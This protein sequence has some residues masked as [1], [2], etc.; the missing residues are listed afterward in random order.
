[1][2]NSNLKTAF[3]LILAI[4]LVAIF[5]FISQTNSFNWTELYRYQGKQPYD[6]KLVHD[7][8]EN[9]VGSANFSIQDKSFQSQQLPSNSA[10]V[11]IGV[12]AFYDPEE[13]DSLLAWVNQ[14]NTA[15]FAVK[16]LD[17]D[18]IGEFFDS[19]T[20]P[21]ILKGNT[22]YLFDTTVVATLLHPAFKGQKANFEYI[23]YQGPEKYDFG[24][25]DGRLFCPD[26]PYEPL[27]LVQNTHV[28]FIR[29]PLGKG[30]LLAHAA[31]VMFSNYFMTSYREAAYVQAVLSHI[32]SKE[33]VWDE[34]HRY[35]HQ[36]YN[37]GSTGQGSTPLEFI[38]EHKSLR[39]A[40]YLIL[41]L[42]L[43]Y[44]VSATRRRQR[45]VKLIE[46]LRN[47]TLEFVQ[48]MG[49]L[50]F[51]QRNH[52]TLIQMQMRYFLH[53]IRERYRV[54]AR[55]PELIQLD[56]LSQR[57]AIPKEQIQAII[58]EYTRLKAYVELS[59]AEAIAFH[60]LLNQF[61]KTCH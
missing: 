23:G 12:Q 58:N 40:F 1:M 34:Y 26:S 42:A 60:K 32:N 19:L 49:R 9:Q 20:C 14:G 37:I 47:S 52:P 55:T 7:H 54:K 5:W 61:Y 44:L 36:E 10:Y 28:N 21:P 31:P 56:I 29:I 48:A 22:A 45:I 24:C 8:L 50:Y 33:I 51:L 17:Y 25:F 35:P 18:L 43:I 15:F 46:P 13:V 2:K 39:W 6:L 30:Q 53:F 27:G 16:A 3:I 57:A 59:D 11:F 41:S 38:L 4:A